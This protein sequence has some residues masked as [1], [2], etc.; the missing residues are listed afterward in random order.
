MPCTCSP[1]GQSHIQVLRAFQQMHHRIVLVFLIFQLDYR[2]QGKSIPMIEV[3]AVLDN[4]RCVFLAPLRVEIQIPETHHR[5][6]LMSQI[7]IG[8]DAAEV[9][10]NDGGF[11]LWFKNPI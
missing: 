4:V 9:R 3:A 2:V 8:S 7:T 1:L 10:R 6:P 5:R 11:R